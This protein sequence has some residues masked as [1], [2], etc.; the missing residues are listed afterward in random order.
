LKY[1][2]GEIVL[3]YSELFDKNIEGKITHRYYTN[4]KRKYWIKNSINNE[5]FDIN[6][7]KIMKKENKNE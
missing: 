4:D 7:N 6:E 3:F 5:V 1:N 2:I